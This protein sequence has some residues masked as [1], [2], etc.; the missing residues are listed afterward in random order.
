MILRC[1]IILYVQILSGLENGDIQD[2]NLRRYDK[3]K[4][5]QRN[6]F[7]FSELFNI[8]KYVK[9]RFRNRGPPCYFLGVKR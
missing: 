9:I 1:F 7:K 4:T 5:C 6:F 8:E 3:I 2:L